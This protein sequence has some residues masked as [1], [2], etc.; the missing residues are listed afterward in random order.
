MSTFKFL[1]GYCLLM[2]V[3]FSSCSKEELEYEGNLEIIL[4]ADG[5]S[6]VT[7]GD[8]T[9]LNFKAILTHSFKKEITL[10]FKSDSLVKY[11]AVFTLP[12]PVKIPANETVVKFKVTFP[13]K[14]NIYDHILSKDQIFDLQVKAVE[15]IN[16]SISMYDKSDKITVKRKT[17]I[18][19]LTKRERDLLKTW[20]AAGVNVA[21]FIGRIPV[22]VK[23]TVSADDRAFLGFTSVNKT[24]TG[25]T[26][27]GINAKATNTKVLLDMKDN[28]FG[29][30]EFMRDLFRKATVENETYWYKPGHKTGPSPAAK[31][32]VEQLLGTANYT[33]WKNKTNVFGMSVEELELKSDGTIKF[34]AKDNV[35]DDSPHH[36]SDP[37]K[38]FVLGEASMG[39]KHS[40]I[41]FKYNFPLYDYVYDKVK[42]DPKGYKKF[43]Q[44]GSIH[45]D[46]WLINDNIDDDGWWESLFVAP[47]S[48]VDFANGKVKFTFVFDSGVTKGDYYRADVTYTAP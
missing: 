36:D 25:Y 39:Y 12:A 10:E 30:Q 27:I 15:G 34:W 45:P 6:S 28:P 1:F 42:T 38:D 19:P 18:P 44:G 2:A 24:F 31:Y 48:T 37:T 33:K 5:S 8:A 40:H 47:S 11:P 43:F 9:T 29:L 35:Y 22:S 23:L 3:L 21:K 4:T 16:N 14:T 41:D 46:H 7:E 13:A 26:N 32:V 20:K 17:S